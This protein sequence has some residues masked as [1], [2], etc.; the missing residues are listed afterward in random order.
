ME[1]KRNEVPE[2]IPCEDKETSVEQAE[3][4]TVVHAEE[5]INSS[6]V[7]SVEE[8]V[9]DQKIAPV[10]DKQ[11][12]TL[13]ETPQTA[14]IA[15]SSSD[16]VTLFGKNIPKKPLIIASAVAAAAVILTVTL[17]LIFAKHP[18]A[19]FFGK[20]EKENNYQMT[21][22][23]SDIPF[24]G[25]MSFYTKVDDNVSYISAFLFEAESYTER[26]GDDVYTY[27]K[28]SNDKWVKVKN[29][30]NVEDNSTV[31]QFS[32]DYAELLNPKNYEKDGKNKYVQ[33]DDVKF[34]SYDNVVITID[35]DCLTI[36]MDVTS[37]GM[38]FRVK[39]VISDVGDV[40]LTLPKVE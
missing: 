22:T 18:I 3:V 24:F 2:N 10:E 9:E 33:K 7:A 38:I 34:D 21:V 25:T 12:E 6:E 35:D 8:M 15:K 14:E 37:E 5:T 30:S 28:D 1:E 16:I 32:K 29:E 27:T 23:M 31:N 19:K 39:I 17:I 4:D 20:M 13:T 36:E 11:E 40:E 26:V